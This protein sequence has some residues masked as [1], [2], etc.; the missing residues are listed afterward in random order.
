MLWFFLGDEQSSGFQMFTLSEQYIGNSSPPLTDSL[1]FSVSDTVNNVSS[2]NW[3]KLFSTTLNCT[4][5]YIHQATMT[6]FITCSQ[7]NSG[8]LGF[9]SFLK[10][11]EHNWGKSQ[12]LEVPITP[13][14]YKAT[15]R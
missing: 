5:E 11:K 8:L 9:F 2:I 3:I 6:V 4:A 12:V 1:I 14:I 10:S 13:T 15:K 7:Y